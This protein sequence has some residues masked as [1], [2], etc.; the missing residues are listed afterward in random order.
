MNIAN[1]ITIFRIALIPAIIYSIFRAGWE[2]T[3]LFYLIASILDV[4][5]GFIARKMNKTSHFGA[6]LD[7][8]GDKLMISS[9][10]VSYILI[11]NIPW[12]WVLLILFRDLAVVIAAGIAKFFVGRKK[13]VLFKAKWSGKLVTFSQF[14]AIISIILE[15]EYTKY[16]I[17]ATFLVSI[18]CLSDYWNEWK[19]RVSM[20]DIKLN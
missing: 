5:D 13:R 17:Y 15:T 6:V 2:Q 7:V 12:H 9:I 11:L 14:L 1:M 20:K 4:V 8:V 16:L 19:K 18:W 10:V 3:L